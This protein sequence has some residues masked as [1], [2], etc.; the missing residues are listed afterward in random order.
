M[1]ISK[2]HYFI[3]MLLYENAGNLEIKD[4]CIA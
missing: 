1:V 3:I 4:F 2:K